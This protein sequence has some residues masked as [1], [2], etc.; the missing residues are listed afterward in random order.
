MD[1][2]DLDPVTA[3][4]A[5]SAIAEDENRRSLWDHIDAVLRVVTIVMAFVICF[6]LKTFLCP[7]KN[8][9][10]MAMITVPMIAIAT[11]TSTRL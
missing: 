10:M 3:E 6:P 1:N 8:S 9:D 5:A 11:S 7:R 4:A 2:D